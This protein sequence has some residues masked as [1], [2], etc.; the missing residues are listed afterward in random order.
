MVETLNRTGGVL[1][2]AQKQ[3]VVRHNAQV[4][5][6]VLAVARDLVSSSFE[7]QFRGGVFCNNFFEG[8]SVLPGSR[9]ALGRSERYKKREVVILRAPPCGPPHD[10]R[11]VGRAPL[12]RGA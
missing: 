3:T 10:E 11:R 9:N 12:G 6:G 7:L 1:A 4:S 8:V 5:G 2:G